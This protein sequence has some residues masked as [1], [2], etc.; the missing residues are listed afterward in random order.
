MKH[1]KT[2]EDFVNEDVNE[3]KDF[4]LEVAVRDAKKALNYLNDEYR[5]KFKTS[6]SNKYS[7]KKEDDA[8]NALQDLED[9]EIEVIDSNL[10]ESIVN[11]GKYSFED[12]RKEFVENPYGIG[13]NTVEDED[14]IITFRF[15][16]S[17]KRDEAIKK[18]KSLG[19]PVNKIGKSKQDRAYQYKYELIVS[20]SVINEQID[21]MTINDFSYGFVEF[22]DFI[23]Q[24]SKFMDKDTIKHLKEAI[25]HL[26]QAW[27]NETDAHGVDF[28]KYKIKI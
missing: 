5:N 20:E 24:Y 7:F 18:L 22:Y 11:E 6:G 25:K 14:D 4:Y 2:F 1:I 27:E 9:L 17:Y 16:D 23:S 19:Y 28:T 12:I 15:S 21:S 13:A 3:G 8:Y 26:D 10:D